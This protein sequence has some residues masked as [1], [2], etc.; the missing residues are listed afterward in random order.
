MFTADFQQTPFWWD[1]SPLC[2]TPTATNLPSRADVV[3]IGSGYTGL[4]AAIQIARHGRPVMVLDAESIGSGCSTRNGGQVSTSLK[5]MFPMLTEKFGAAKALAILQEGNHALAWIESFIT[6]NNIDCSFQKV[7]R[8]HAAHSARAFRAL[9]KRNSQTPPQLG[10]SRYVVEADQQHA[11]IGSTYYH[12]GIIYPE[13]ASIDPGRYHHG[14]LNCATTSGA[15][16]IGNCPVGEIRRKSAGGFELETAK[17]TITA[18]DVVLATSGY[19]GKISPWQ[20]RRIIPIGSYV[21]AT[22]PLSESLIT[23]LIPNN[24]VITDTRKLVMYYRTCPERRRI[25]LGGRV[26]SHEIDTRKSAQL[27]Y[28]EML[29]IFPELNSVKISH[30]W[31]GFV[32][33]T[34]DKAPHIGKHN[35]I[36]YSMG[37]CGSGISLASYFGMRLGLKMLGDPRGATALDD[38]PF[39]TRAYYRG[40]PWFLPPS[41]FYYRCLDAIT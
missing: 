30:S 15:E 39:Q 41:I 8:F 28:R 1:R 38:L 21:I 34:F 35:G 40:N 27:L 9:Q 29:R 33:Y 18:T 24:R 17:G 23:R 26:A 25:L 3:V 20:H 11:E 31:M 4:S 6:E 2:Q 19:T 14:L 22:E 32:G 12:G 5:P 7:G 36:Y 16:V 10:L 13:C 37:Y